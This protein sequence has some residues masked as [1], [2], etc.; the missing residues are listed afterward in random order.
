MDFNGFG[1]YS[2]YTRKSPKGC[3][4]DHCDL[5]FS[6]KSGWLLCEEQITESGV[7]QVNRESVR[8]LL[9]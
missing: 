5:I 3:R 8:R 7:E 6:F 4:L 1:F 9:R 2:E